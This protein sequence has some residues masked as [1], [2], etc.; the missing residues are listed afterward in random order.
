VTHQIKKDGSKEFVRACVG[1]YTIT[2]DTYIEK[3][4]I[5]SWDED[6]SKIKTNFTYKLKLR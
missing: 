1:T 5:A 3:I 4:D 2:N 6:L